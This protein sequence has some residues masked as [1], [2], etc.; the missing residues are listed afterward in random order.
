[1]EINYQMSRL[2]TCNRC[3]TGEHPVPRVGTSLLLY[4]GGKQS[5]FLMTIAQPPTVSINGLTPH[6]IGEI[7]HLKDKNQVEFL[8]VCSVEGCGWE[9][10]NSGLQVSKTGEL[11][12]VPKFEILEQVPFFMNTEEFED[13]IDSTSIEAREFMFL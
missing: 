13:L 8:K 4:G 9:K 6:L 12:T 2:L 7:R 3:A 1:M 5:L 11:I 10:I